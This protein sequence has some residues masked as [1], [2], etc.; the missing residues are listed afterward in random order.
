MS[1]WLRAVGVVV[2][3]VGLG[4]GCWAGTLVL[5]DAHFA[6]AVASY[7][8]H[9]DHPLIEGEYY[10]AATRHY[11]LIAIGVGTATTGVVF[12]SLLFGLAA[13]LDRVSRG[14]D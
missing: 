7:L 14:G 6:D 13:V 11:T 9:P 5:Q 4:V 1:R 12:A 8:R 10:A 3:A 2:L